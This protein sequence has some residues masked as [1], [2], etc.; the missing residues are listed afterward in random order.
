MNS[1]T[2]ET[3]P[4]KN[5]SKETMVVV[6]KDGVFI[7]FVRKFT[8]T[9]TTKNPWQACGTWLPGKPNKFL[10]SFWPVDGGKEAAINAVIVNDGKA[11]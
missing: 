3:I 4:A 6:H 9:K 11:E 7:G 1:I 5:G 8:D 2:F 10:G